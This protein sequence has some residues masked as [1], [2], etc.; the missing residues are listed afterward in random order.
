MS[1]K[2]V[3]FITPIPEPANRRRVTS[4]VQA[5]G[6]LEVHVSGGMVMLSRAGCDSV[7]VPMT[8]VKAI[9]VEAEAA[10]RS[11]SKKGK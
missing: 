1:V 3:D 9:I 11:E 5:G 7:M 8:N 6:D 10:P 2:R 4:S